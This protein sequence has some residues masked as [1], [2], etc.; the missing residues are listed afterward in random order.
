MI[1]SL[2]KPWLLTSL[3][4]LF[5]LLAASALPS[6]SLADWDYREPVYRVVPLNSSDTLRDHV[7]RGYC[8]DPWACTS[9]G[10]GG[11][12]YATATPTWIRFAELD[13]SLQQR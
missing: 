11:G 6:L 5:L 2:R 8:D 7:D 10:G 3:L 12:P 1:K 13:Q 9:G 4:A